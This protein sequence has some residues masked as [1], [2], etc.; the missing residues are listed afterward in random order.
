[1]DVANRPLPIDFM[2]KKSKSAPI[3]WI[4]KN[5]HASSGRQLYVEQL[6]KYIQV[7]SYGSCLNNKDF[8]EGKTRE[9]LMSEYKFYLAIENANCDDYVTEKLVDTLKFSAV[10]IVDGPASYD[11]YLPNQRAAIRMDAYPDPREL[12]DYIRFLDENDDAYLAYLEHRRTALTKAP[13]ERLD[14]SFVKLWSDQTA[15]DY[16]VSWCSICRHM[17]STWTL[18][19][20]NNSSTLSESAALGAAAAALEAKNDEKD[21]LLI[22]NSCSEPGKWSYAQD[23]PPFTGFTFT[24]TPKDEFARAVL[25]DES[26]SLSTTPDL[27]ADDAYNE[28]DQHSRFLP[29]VSI[30]FALAV[31]A[32]IAVILYQRSAKSKN[33]RT[34]LPA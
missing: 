6:M 21:L 2:K 33:K 15:H 8:P 14:A 13:L 12:A 11:G 17:A 4:A 20:N 3:L 28:S 26:S 1:M 19:N 30:S 29:L 31:F 22:D 18:R 23:G 32:Y 24:P 7:D 9:Q 27:L 34:P 25:R 10:P 16:R 5:C